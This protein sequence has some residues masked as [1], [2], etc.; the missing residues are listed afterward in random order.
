[1][2]REVYDARKS[3]HPQRDIIVG[4]KLDRAW[5]DFLDSWRIYCIKLFTVGQRIAGRS[6]LPYQAKRK[7]EGGRER[8]IYIYIY[9]YT[10]RIL[11][12]KRGIRTH[13]EREKNFNGRGRFKIFAMKKDST[14]HLALNTLTFFYNSLIWISLEN[15]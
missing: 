1:M 10:N 9:I 7:K 13:R 5:L 12:E 14:L 6:N 3:S 11:S 8:D 15:K 2:C 4:T